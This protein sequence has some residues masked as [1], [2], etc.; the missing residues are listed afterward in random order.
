MKT[1]EDGPPTDTPCRRSWTLSST[2]TKAGPSTAS[3]SAIPAMAC[4]QPSWRSWVRDFGNTMLS[5][6]GRL[7]VIYTNTSW[8]NQC[9]GNP[10]GFGDYPLWVAAYPSSPTNNAGAVPRLAGATTASGSTAAPGRSLGDSNVWNGDYTGLQNFARFADGNSTRFAI[11]PNEFHIFMQLAAAL[12]TRSQTG[13]PINSLLNYYRLPAKLAKISC[14]RLSNGPAVGRFARDSDGSIYMIDAGRRLHVPSCSM[15]NDF[16]GGMCTSWLPL[17][18]GQISM[19][20]DAG[21]LANAT[22][23]PRELFNRV[24]NDEARVLRRSL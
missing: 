23:S 2:L 20:S 18:S 4:R 13:K 12:S 11:G 9:L 1:V 24:R 15:I 21:T 16:G 14:D 10:A 17:S 6:T 22:V 19:F 3:T 8:W 7:P 5:M